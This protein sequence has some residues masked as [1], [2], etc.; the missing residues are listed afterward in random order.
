MSDET[1]EMTE[2]FTTFLTGIVPEH[3]A[4]LSRI[5]AAQPITFHVDDAAER[6]KFTSRSEPSGPPAGRRRAE[7]LGKA[8]GTLVLV[9]SRAEAV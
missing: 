9:L 6:I 2:A 7:G 3:A 8:L 5:I 4:D 1:V